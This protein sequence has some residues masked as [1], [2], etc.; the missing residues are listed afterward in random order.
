MEKAASLSMQP[1][2]SDS[3]QF[4]H[5]LFG[6]GFRVRREASYLKLPATVS[7]AVPGNRAASAAVQARYRSP[8]AVK[9]F[10]P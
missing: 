2:L 4:S 8:A 9:N 3:H 6:R 1:S 7:G 5:S 10:S